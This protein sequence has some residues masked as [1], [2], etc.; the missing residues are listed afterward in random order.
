MSQSGVRCENNESEWSKMWEE[1][2]ESVR[3]VT[4]PV[5]AFHSIK[6]LIS[7]ILS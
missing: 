1:S 5:S 6:N 2:K 4:S 3:I 7:L